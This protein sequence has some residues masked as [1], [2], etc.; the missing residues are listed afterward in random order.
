M[1]DAM[2]NVEQRRSWSERA[3]RSLSSCIRRQA[4]VTPEIFSEQGSFLKAMK[5]SF[6][7]SAIRK[8]YSQRSGKPD[9]SYVAQLHEIS[10][11]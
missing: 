3:D 6:T 1:I 4:V 8:E 5:P 9:Q 10:F 11:F 7:K 2:V